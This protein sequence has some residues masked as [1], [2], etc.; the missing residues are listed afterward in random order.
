MVELGQ[1]ESRISEF[2]KKNLRIVAVS[3][4]SV[5]DTAQTQKKFPHLIVL[6]DAEENLSKAVA[7]LGPLR[8]LNGAETDSPTTIL[9]DRTGL[10][11]WVFRPERM[12][13]RLPPDDLLKAVDENLHQN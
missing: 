11:R 6:S 12:I 10:V 4:D 8:G 13:E 1:L 3:L 9:V 5:E 7:V 2:E